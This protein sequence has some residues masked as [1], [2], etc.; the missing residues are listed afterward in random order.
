MHDLRIE[1]P[2]ACN[3]AFHIAGGAHLQRVEQAQEAPAHHGAHLCAAL[4]VEE[5][6][7]RAAAARQLLSVYPVLRPGRHCRASPPAMPPHLHG[8]RICTYL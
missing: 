8:A 3:L 6:Q 5:H 2:L 1:V 7:Q 4:G